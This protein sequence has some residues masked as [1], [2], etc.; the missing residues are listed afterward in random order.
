MLVVVAAAQPPS[1]GE[2]LYVVEAVRTPDA[3]R[4]DG[5][6]DETVWTTARPALNFRY[7]FPVDTGFTRFDTEVRLCFDD[8]HLYIAAVCRQPR[9]SYTMQSLRRDF[10][11]GASDVLNVLLDPTKDG[12]N[13]FL[14]GVNPLNVQREA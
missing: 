2:D 9:E 3:V 1:V 7:Q 6:L 12:L 13:G 5:L 10:P 8:K 4:I 11:G 14:F